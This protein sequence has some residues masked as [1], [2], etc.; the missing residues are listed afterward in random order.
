[1]SDFKLMQRSENNEMDSGIQIQE[2][3][4]VSEI[5][6]SIL[7]AR[8][9]P[10]NEGQSYQAIIEA[11]KRH[12]LAEQAMYTYPRGGTQVTGASIRLAEVLARC[13]GNCRIGITVRSQDTEKTEARAYAYDLQ[14]NYMIDQDFTVPHKR[15]TKKGTFRLTDERDI[16]ELV[17]N[18]GSRILRGC[19]L[20]LIPADVVEDAVEQVNKTLL[21]SEVPIA[22][23][24]KKMVNAFSELG[25]KV[26][27]LEKRLG[28][29]LDATIPQEIVNLKGIY[30]S[31]KDGMATREDF[32][33]IQN[34]ISDDVKQDLKLVIDKNKAN[35]TEPLTTEVTPTI[36]TINI[37]EL[38]VI[39]ELLQENKIDNKKR[40]AILQ[41]FNVSHVEQLDSEQV[42]DFIAQLL[43]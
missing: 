26:E 38:T 36:T 5:Q 11:C 41:K 29:N 40:D 16:R 2:A 37:D 9:Y 19:I 15:T 13:W 17:S 18:I 10:R 39:K 20:R 33:E 12:S 28:H 6:A 4:A 31:I 24:V 23:Q 1:M 32:F 14:T 7:M 22:E 43:G 3:R 8:Q 30:K 21:S 27:H 35:T 34:K 25:V 42:D